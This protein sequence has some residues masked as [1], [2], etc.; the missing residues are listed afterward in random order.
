MRAAAP[1]P[2]LD[3]TQPPCPPPH[4]VAPLTTPN[5]TSKTVLPTLKSAADETVKTMPYRFGLPA[6][7][8]H[9]LNTEAVLRH[10][11]DKRNEQ[12]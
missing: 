9:R 4:P 7:L 1:W 5:G 12:G 11:L 2:N 3:S 8:I 10:G 6:L